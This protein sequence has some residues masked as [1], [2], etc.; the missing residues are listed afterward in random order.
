VAL[1]AILAYPWRAD[2]QSPPAAPE[3]I[4]YLTLGQGAVPIGVGGSAASLGATVETALRVADGNAVGVSLTSKP[5]PAAQDLELTYELP[6]PTTF[7][8]FA[9]PN[10]LETP[11]PSA[12]FVRDV[13]VLGAATGA[14]G[15][16]VRLA[17]AVLSTHPRRGQVTE[18]TLHARTAV[19]WVKV[20]LSG[21]I[22]ALAPN[23]F[24]EFSEI[25]GNGTQEQPPLATAFA[26]T[27]KGRGLLVELQQ[28]G[29]VVSGCYDRGGQ[30]TGTVTGNVL[31]A[32]GVAQA[33]RIPSVFVLGIAGDG[34]LRGVRSTNSGPFAFYAADRAPGTGARPS[35]QLPPPTLGC[36]AVIHGIGFDFDSAA[37]RPDAQPVLAR[38]FDG[39]RAESSQAI[40]IEG[41]T[42]SEGADD[43]NLRLS[44]RRAAAVV[45]DL[46]A[47]GLPAARLRA[48]GVGE[49]RPVASDDDESG[50]SLNR[51]VE[52]R[53]S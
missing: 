44:E 11:S 50:R 1:A 30:L 16:F 21:G 26:G 35:C 12:T 46:V 53:C 6:A 47:K 3:R 41:H 24:L 13:E 33:N 31:R 38:L 20:R 52:V 51:R 29:P 23:M 40:V 9:V 32:T 28:D 49:G 10:V 19:R 7:D 25:V 39:L 42:S 37:I 2:G 22:Q 17:S 15:P 27:W 4:D 14:D 18:L 43:Y 8:R 5:G 48:I 36:G 34:T 45:A